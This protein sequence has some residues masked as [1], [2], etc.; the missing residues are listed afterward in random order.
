[1]SR[2]VVTD[3]WLYK[4]MPIVDAAMLRA[5]E[6][7]VDYNYI[8]SE[9]YERKMKKVIRQEARMWV[10]DFMR[11]ARK[12]A[13]VVI[14]ILAALFALTMSVEAYRTKFFQ[15]VK[16]IW[17]DSVIYTYFSEVNEEGF[18][19]MEP[20][21][22]PEG[23]SEVS[24]VSVDDYFFIMYKDS[25]G[26]YISYDQVLATNERYNVMDINYEDQE[27]LEVNDGIAIISWYADDYVGVFYRTDKYIY[28]LN[29]NCL[30]INEIEN[31]IENIK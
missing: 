7:E 20:Q 30:T 6:S 17:E 13:V 15:T 21:Y 24:R 14:C 26:N 10:G 29:G 23:Y 4:Y 9:N 1:M 11:F 22:I 31:I 5:I 12:A 2:V 16:E 28:I 18:R 19:E 3:E 27:M 25:E 8:F